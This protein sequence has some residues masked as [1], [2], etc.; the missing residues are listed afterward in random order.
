[1]SML[2]YEWTS[3]RKNCS[4]LP[5]NGS[6]SSAP[7]ASPMNDI[8]KETAMATFPSTSARPDVRFGFAD[9][10]HCDLKATGTLMVGSGM[11][12]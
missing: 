4:K 3:N 7:T 9:M 2:I 8:T 6:K 1:M 5:S 12:G 10:H 11:H